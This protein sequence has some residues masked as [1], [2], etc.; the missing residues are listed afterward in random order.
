MTIEQGTCAV[1]VGGQYGSEAKGK[2]VSYL[3][4]EFN[5]AIRTGSPNS[6]ACV[7]DDL[8]NVYKL[9]QIPAT[10]LNQDCLLCI[11][12]GALINPEILRNEAI[13][14]KTRGRLII[15]RNAGIIEK[16]HIEQE[17]NTKMTENIG[18][19]SKG[20]GA[21]MADRASLNPNFKFA[22]TE[23]T[24]FNIT[25]VS[26]LAN[27]FLDRAKNVLIEGTQGY[28]LSLIHSKEYPFTTSRDTS[29]A[30]F[31]SEAGIS[32]RRVTDI[33]L[34]IRS[35]SIRVGGN[36]G[37]LKNEIDWKTVSA[38]AGKPIIET[39]TVTNRVRRV[40]KFDI[41]LVK[42]AICCNQPNHIAF[43]FL[44][45]LYPQDENKNQWKS[46]SSDAQYFINNL[47]DQLET[48]ITLIG[49]GPRNES[50]IDRRK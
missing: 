17:I 32:P 10:F 49:T 37:P 1:V 16:R 47:E 34:V 14:T 12:A 43:Q 31:L 26:H 9:Q 2:V 44:N 18:S 39:T 45:Y 20:C 38:R 11:G 8:N 22:R 50:M 19:T 33:Y 41:D 40:G 28:G 36:S 15:D 30:A 6:G 4:S 25:N 13:L 46:L 5:L 21:A 35:Y 48:P 27:N 7:Y 29:A 23:L 3:A 42:E 24:D